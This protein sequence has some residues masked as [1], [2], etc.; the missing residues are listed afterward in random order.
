MSRSQRKKDNQAAQ[1][2]DRRC[3]IGYV[4]PDQ[5]DALWMN[6]LIDMIFFDAANQ[7]YI[8]PRGGNIHVGSGPRIA[9]ARNLV[10]QTFMNWFSQPEWLLMMDTDMV[11]SP[12]ILHRMMME[13]HPVE[14]PFVGALCFAGGKGSTIYPT[15][16][17]LTDEGVT[18]RIEEYPKDAMVKVHATGAAFMLIHRSVFEKIYDQWHERTVYPWFAETEH[19]RH[20]FGEDVTFCMRAT[21]V[22]CPIYVHT[23]IQ[24]GHSKLNLLDEAMYERQQ[25]EIARIGKIGRAHV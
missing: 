9:S 13:A 5:V 11:F 4:H 23:G 8:F 14:R 6:S 20:E 19:N 24:V 16:Y 3:F 7:G 15:L 25:E 12:D 10:V 1:V 17:R 18:E 22:G 2:A 21:Q